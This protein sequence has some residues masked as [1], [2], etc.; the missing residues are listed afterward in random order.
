[1]RP[2][3]LTS[4]SFMVRRRMLWK[5]CREKAARVVIQEHSLRVFLCLNN[6]EW[7]GLAKYI[8]LKVHSLGW[9]QGEKT[10]TGCNYLE[11]IC[12]QRLGFSVEYSTAMVELT[13]LPGPACWLLGLTQPLWADRPGS[14]CMCWSCHRKTGLCISA[15]LCWPCVCLILLSAK[16]CLLSIELTWIC[17]IFTGG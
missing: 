10:D 5:E 2:G 7:A 1:M 12:K 15:D 13:D 9:H 14:P 8:S 4:I 16:A 3:L 11:H 17:L 6:S